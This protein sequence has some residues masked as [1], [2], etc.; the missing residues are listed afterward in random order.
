MEFIADLWARAFTLD[1]LLPA[2]IIAI[3]LSLVVRGIVPAVIVSIIAV[4]VDALI[5]LGH[6]IIAA[7]ALPADPVGRAMELLQAAPLDVAAARFV[8]YLFTI[9][10]LG[11]AWR[12][13]TR[14]YEGRP[15]VV[16][17]D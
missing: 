11:E 5:P 9:W 10:V 16:E 14:T 2:A 13:M 8:F 17:K 6:E 15:M 3:V 4:V 12:D 7:G 1:W